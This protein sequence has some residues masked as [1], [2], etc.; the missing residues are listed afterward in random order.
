[1]RSRPLL[2]AVLVLG[3]FFPREEGA[4]AVH[5]QGRWQ[6]WYR[7]DA[8]P[9]RWDGPLPLVAEAVEWSPAAT[10]LEVGRLRLSGP[11]EAWRVGVVL[12]RI[13]PARVR[14][15]LHWGMA[16]GDRKAWTIDS[17]PDDAILALNAGMFNAGAPFGWTVIDGQ[18]RGTIG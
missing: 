15:A 8:A 2:A 6:T 9:A 12:I 7:A 5:A 16:A 3:A 18:E 11:G 10:G 13:D 14:W 17:A 4:L 1:M